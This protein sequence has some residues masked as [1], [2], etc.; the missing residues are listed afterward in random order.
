M[1]NFQI[2]KTVGT[3]L[4]NLKFAQDCSKIKA[5]FISNFK[6]LILTSEN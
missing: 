3:N 6:G 2:M 5:N 1:K 4:I